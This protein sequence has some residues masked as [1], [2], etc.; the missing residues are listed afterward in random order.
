[1]NI[2]ITAVAA[3]LMLGM[4]LSQNCFAEGG[5]YYAPTV[6]EYGNYGDYGNYGNYGNYGDYGDYGFNY[7]DYYGDSE[8]SYDKLH[9]IP[10]FEG[11]FSYSLYSYGAEVVGYSGESKRVEIPAEVKGVK[12]TGIGESAFAYSDIEEVVISEGVEV[13]GEEAFSYCSSLKEV[14]IPSTVITISKKA[15]E[16]CKA[17]TKIEFGENV[18]EIGFGCFQYCENLQEATFGNKLVSIKGLAFGRCKALKEISLPEGVEEIGSQAFSNCKSLEKVYIPESVTTI[19]YDAFEYTSP[20]FVIT[21]KY[22][23]YARR[24]AGYNDL[25]FEVVPAE[26]REILPGVIAVCWGAAG[27]VCLILIVVGAVR[28]K[29]GEE[30]KAL[31]KESKDSEK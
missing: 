25:R 8:N 26:G 13:I 1:M 22:D 20:A 21:G 17:L 4:V 30:K 15:F 2:K 29:R 11:D 10:Y 27:V 31:E 12:V 28:Y 5:E 3:A 6:E 14:N 9:G 7:P 16:Y 23:S 19:G 24:Y 18:E